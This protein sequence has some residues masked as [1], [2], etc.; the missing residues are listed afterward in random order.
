[1][2]YNR[3]MMKA[4]ALALS[5]PLA[6]CVVGSA[7]M[8]GDD[9][10]PPPGDDQPP[11]NGVS[12]HITADTTWMD[13]TFISGLT[14][15]DPG[16]TVTIPAGA[17]IRVGTNGSVV[18]QGTLD[19]SAGTSAAKITI[20]PDA[21]AAHFGP[22]ESGIT[23]ATGGS[24][25]YHYVTQD[26]SG[27][28]TTGGTFTAV[29]SELRNSAGDWLVMAGGTVNVTYSTLGVVTGTNT[30]HCNMHFN[31][32]SP[33]TV[34]VSHTNVGMAPYGIMFYGGTQADFTYDNWTG[35]QIDVD[36]Q[37][38]VTGDFSNS[39]FPKG[40]P[41]APGGATFTL[42]NISTTTMVVDAGPRP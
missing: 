39:Y 10:Q 15:I 13:D 16:V 19:A 24:I 32:G 20:H 41:V 12:G 33:N 40:A 28:A 6:A 2:L 11:P 14:T 27:L 31:S 1:L 3:Y 8:T 7:Q 38:G 4:L 23:A 18:V 35:N 34:T 5:L 22:G 30:T 42:T 25:T 36:A 17:T 26:G 37:P 9:N 29:D 21:G